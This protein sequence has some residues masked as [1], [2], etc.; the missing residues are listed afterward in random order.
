MILSIG[1]I[2]VDMIGDKENAYRMFIGGAPF[3]VAVNA[4]QAGAGTGF[5][6]RIGK[7]VAGRF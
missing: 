3:N 2:L 7:D 5:V 4:R 1:E 6:G